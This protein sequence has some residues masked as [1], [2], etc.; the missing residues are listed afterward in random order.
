MEILEFPRDE[1]ETK[2]FHDN[3][4][5]SVFAKISATQGLVFI[6]SI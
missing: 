5:A 6:C 3:A 4:S 1:L 2:R